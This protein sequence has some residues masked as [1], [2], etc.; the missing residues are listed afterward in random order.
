MKFFQ[1]HFL[2]IFISLTLLWAPSNF[3]TAQTKDSVIF[4]KSQLVE[5]INWT[6]YQPEKIKQFP[7][8]VLKMNANFGT[9]SAKE[10]VNEDFQ[11]Y[12]S[13]LTF[14]FVYDASTDFIFKDNYGVRMAFYQF[15]AAHSNQNIKNSITYIGP[16]FVIRIPFDQIPCEFEA[17]VGIGYIEYRGKQ[18]FAKFY[19][20]S[21]GAQFNI[22]VEWKFNPHWGIG[23]NVQSTTGEI[24]KFRHEKNGEKWT[25]TFEV[26]E[27][28]D[29]SQTSVGIGIRYY[30]K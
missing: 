9:R 1:H 28:E 17:S 11:K 16:A 25:T 19:G 4:N 7:R 29:L 12:F 15:R 5:T 21:L 24:T 30:F 2:T 13:H 6:P 8:V 22:G 3:V 27:G 23:L 26:D 14:G 18:S 10:T 20:A